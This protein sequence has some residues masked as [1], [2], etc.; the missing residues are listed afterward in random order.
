MYIHAR[1]YKP[2]GNLLQSVCTLC[3]CNLYA[4]NQGGNIHLVSRRAT[5]KIEVLLYIY[6]SQH[7]RNIQRVK[8]KF[9][10][11]K[12]RRKIGDTCVF[13][14]V[15]ITNLILILN[16]IFVV[17]V[18]SFFFYSVIFENNCKPT[19]TRFFPIPLF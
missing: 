4:C 12:K 19:S 14:F 8:N 16:L 18:V 9:K 1:I 3:V 17:I 7:M 2:L 15:D 11:T 10:F 5:P 6:Q 13:F